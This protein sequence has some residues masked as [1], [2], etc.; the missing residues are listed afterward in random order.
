MAAVGE[1][2]SG[3]GLSS[4]NRTSPTPKYSAASILIPNSQLNDAN[5]KDKAHAVLFAGH[6]GNIG[7]LADLGK[8][9]VAG[10]FGKNNSG[11]RGIF[12]LTVAT[13]PEAEKLIRT[14]SAVKASNFIA[15]MTPWHGSASLRATLEILK[16]IAKA[17]F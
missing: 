3:G 9:A 12:V 2:G 14:D 15:D 6:M 13:L 10:P 7:R 8:F 5:F 4:L 17:T 16:K 11:F 1:C